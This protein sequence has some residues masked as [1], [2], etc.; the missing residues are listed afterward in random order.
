[1]PLAVNALVSVLMKGCIMVGRQ[2]IVVTA[3]EVEE[4]NKS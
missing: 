2:C 1:M 4:Q 3:K